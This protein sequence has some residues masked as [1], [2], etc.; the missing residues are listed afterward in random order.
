[1]RRMADELARQPVEAIAV[2]TV[3]WPDPGTDA[4]SEA[5]G[6]KG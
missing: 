2:G 3:R 6:A 5:A 1:M 4:S